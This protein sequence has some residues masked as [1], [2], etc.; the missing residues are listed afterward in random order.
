M[1]NFILVLILIMN[2]SN[3]A[4][5]DQPDLF[6]P[7]NNTEHR[8]HIIPDVMNKIQVLENNINKTGAKIYDA[9]SLPVFPGFPKVINGQSTE[10]GI[11]CQMD[12]DS[13][14]EIVYGIGTT[15]Q[16]W[17]IDGSIVSGWPKTLTYNTH[18]A[19]SYGVIDGDGESEIV[20]GTA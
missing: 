15:I 12:T 4:V 3:I 20:K 7:K 14:M 11:Y 6:T 18:G 5:C 16:A 1:T 9:D 19:P 8:Y 13:D 2:Y 17:N 10:G